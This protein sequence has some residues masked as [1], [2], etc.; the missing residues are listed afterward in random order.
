MALKEHV[1]INT[2]ANTV[3]EEIISDVLIPNWGDDLLK[4][5]PFL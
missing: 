4:K 5:T 3:V 1:L 2:W